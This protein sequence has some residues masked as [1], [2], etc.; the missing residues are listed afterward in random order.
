MPP[1]FAQPYLTGRFVCER[2]LLGSGVAAT[3][4][5]ASRAFDSISFAGALIGDDAF[6]PKRSTVAVCN[7][8]ICVIEHQPQPLAGVFEPGRVDVCIH[9]LI[10]SAGWRAAFCVT[11]GRPQQRQTRAAFA[12]SNVAR[13]MSVS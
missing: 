8:P 13:M 2:H 6:H 3:L 12:S 10:L 11:R 4:Q 1:G 5:A 7:D 9:D